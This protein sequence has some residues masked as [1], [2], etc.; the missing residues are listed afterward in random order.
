MSP[1]LQFYFGLSENIQ[2]MTDVVFV[3]RM[4]RS[5]YNQTNNTLDAMA[6]NSQEWRDDGFGSWQESR[7]TKERNRDRIKDGAK[8]NMMVALQD[9]VAERNKLL[10]SMAL[11]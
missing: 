4:L 8:K 5:S 1:S 3:G 10:Q 6:S 2:Q 9:Q 11:A 7:G